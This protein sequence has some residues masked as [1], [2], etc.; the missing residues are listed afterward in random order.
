MR[1]YMK[2]PEKS[3]TLLFDLGMCYPVQVLDWRLKF[4]EPGKHLM[5]V[6]DGSGVLCVGQTKV[7]FDR[8]VWYS[9]H[10]YELP[11]ADP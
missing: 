1:L 8:N 6:P 4:A 7:Y 5:E 3:M 9:D 2:T 11:M 10:Y